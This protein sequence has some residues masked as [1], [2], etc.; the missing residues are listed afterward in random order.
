MLLYVAEVGV[1]PIRKERPLNA[2]RKAPL[3]GSCSARN[4]S[5]GEKRLPVHFLS[6]INI[7]GHIFKLDC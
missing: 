7:Y 4:R 6:P 1:C 3:T 2:S 5:G